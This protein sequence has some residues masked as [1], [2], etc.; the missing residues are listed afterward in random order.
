MLFGSPVKAQENPKQASI[1]NQTTE[2][3][4]VFESKEVIEKSL[5]FEDETFKINSD[6]WK[7]EERI[8]DG[9]S[10]KVKVSPQ[11]DVLEYLEWPAKWEQLFITYASFIKHVAQ[12]KWCSV[13]EAEQKY[14]LTKEELQTKMEQVNYEKFYNSQIKG[15]LAG[16]W[17]WYRE[18]CITGVGRF[19][20]WLAGG[21]EAVFNQVSYNSIKGDGENRSF[22][23]SGRLL[24]N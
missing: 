8:V 12:A 15:H 13:Q 2:M 6:N 11:W 1:S 9:S 14:L 19:N 20:M 17:H 5:E 23:F 21:D 18:E 4:H 22:G 24:K 10:Q 16:Y 3:A 7:E